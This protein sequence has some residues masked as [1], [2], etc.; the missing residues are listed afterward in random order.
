MKFLYFEIVEEC[1]EGAHVYDTFLN[2]EIDDKFLEY[3][4]LLGKIVF[5]KNI[6][7]PFFRVIV[8]GKYTL[9]GSLGNDNFRII[10]PDNNGLEYLEEIKLH[11]SNYK[12]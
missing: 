5:M 3:L 6:Q 12:N 8:R 11:I 4:G 9:K 10:L 1:L 2:D 7:K